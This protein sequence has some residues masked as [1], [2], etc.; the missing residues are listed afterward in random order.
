MAV[1][2]NGASEYLY[3][4]TAAP[5]T[6][7][8]TTMAWVKLVSDRNATGLLWIVTDGTEFY[9]VYVGST[10]TELRSN[11][12][13]NTVAVYEMAVGT[14]VHV[15]VVRSGTS[16]LIYINGVLDTTHTFAGSDFVPTTIYIGSD[17]SAYTNA[18]FASFKTWNAVLTAAEIANEVRTY[19]PQRLAD[20]RAFWPMI[21]RG[22]GNRG[23][24]YSGNGLPLTEAGTLDDVDGPP[25]SWGAPV[26]WYP[27]AAGASTQTVNANAI[28]SGATVYQPA[29]QPGSVTV[30]ANLIASAETVHQPAVQPGAVTIAPNLIA[31]GEAVYEPAVNVGA[32]T[33]A[34]EAIASAATVID[35]VTVG[36]CTVSALAMALGLTVTAPVVTAG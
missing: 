33:V 35:D 27:Y 12:N 22:A 2:P 32:V 29:V 15:A 34:V 30:S 6:A 17:T 10:G 8:H 25:I 14:W 16:N 24:D 7:N 36:S 23:I 4:T 19:R 20:L 5:T 26:V 31:S 11:M 9:S 21:D 18:A 28:A 3:S 13:T 1:N